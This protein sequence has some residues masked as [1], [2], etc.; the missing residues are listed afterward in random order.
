MSEGIR[1]R[2][3]GRLTAA[4]NVVRAMGLS[5][6]IPQSGYTGAVTENACALAGARQQRIDQAP[7]GISEYTVTEAD[8][9]IA[10]D[11]GHSAGRSS[12]G[13]REIGPR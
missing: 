5:A 10:G 8:L 7:S 12:F 9:A 6:T 2:P 3:S 13:D 11:D 1:R 4:A